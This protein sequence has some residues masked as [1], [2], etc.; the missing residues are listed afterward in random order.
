SQARLWGR[1]ATCGRVALGL[2]R[3]QRAPPI[4]APDAIRPHTHR[5]SSRITAAFRSSTVT[6]TL[7]P[8]TAGRLDSCHNSTAR[9]NAAGSEILTVRGVRV[10]LTTQRYV[11]PAPLCS[12]AFTSGSLDFTCCCTPAHARRPAKNSR[13]AGAGP[14][15][16]APPRKGP[17]KRGFPA[18][19]GVSAG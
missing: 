14:R 6:A 2:R 13:V 7:F 5:Y 18:P 1:W 19:G 16:E 3:A 10:G 11:P 15:E 4:A 8:L 12:R 17:I 9:W